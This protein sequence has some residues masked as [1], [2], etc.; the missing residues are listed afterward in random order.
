VY[1]EP[2]TY[3]YAM[4]EYEGDIPA[5]AR[6]VHHISPDDVRPGAPGVVCREEWVRGMLSA[7]DL[8]T[9]YAAHNAAFDKKFLPE[10]DIPW[11]CTYRCAMHIWPDAPGHSNQVLRYHLGVEP[12]AA[13]LK[14]LAPH[15]ALYDAA[16]TAGI[17][18]FMLREHT[19]ED[20][21]RFTSSPVLLRT[22]RFGKHRGEL[23]KDVPVDYCRWILR[24]GGFDEDIM[25]TARVYAAS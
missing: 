4:I 6:A 8:D 10:F 17:L 1:G 11:I 22:V 23:W 19:V 5:Q 16:V 12:P 9:V 3:G 13:M 25:H 18:Q 2:G 20:L 21:L 14:D 7:V 15:R 24:T